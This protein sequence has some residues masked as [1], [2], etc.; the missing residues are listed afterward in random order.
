MR[1]Y[2]NELYHH[3]ILG[4]K[5]GKLNGPPYP[6]GYSKHSEKEKRL[7]PKSKID[8]KNDKNSK[9]SNPN[10]SKYVKIG[11][12]VA[13]TALVAYGAY[14]IYENRDLLIAEAKLGKKNVDFIRNSDKF[15]T[16]EPY[17]KKLQGI[18]DQYDDFAKS[19]SPESSLS[20]LTD[21]ELRGLQAYTTPLYKEVNA[22]LRE[23]SVDP[24]ASITTK[25]IAE[26]CSSALNK[27]KIDTDID[28]Q[29][30]VNQTTARKMI[31]FKTF[32]ELQNVAR[33]LGK[34]SEIMHLDSLE[35]IINKDDGIMSTAV[36]FKLPNGKTHSVA[37][38]FSSQEGVIFDIK[39]SKGQKGLFI[40]P[41]SEMK[42]ERELVF[43]PGSAIAM[44]GEFKV[45]DGIIHVFAE[46]VQD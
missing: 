31:G 29:R 25:S 18:I 13:G 37:D 9:K 33:N 44:T 24:T 17:S 41:F 7:N 15:P 38:Y 2:G 8:G 35:D 21:D 6:L 12:A 46:L 10:Y 5:W 30:G 4:Q 23:G 36:P 43:A 16:A 3:G 34:N 27:T 26:L 14:K 45:V 1:Y 42:G 19:I 11:L 32:T 28:V 20:D 40:A 39:A 22:Y